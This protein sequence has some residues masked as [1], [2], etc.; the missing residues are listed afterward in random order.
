MPGCRVNCWPAPLPWTV[1]VSVP[2]PP[3]MFNWN[4]PGGVKVCELPS[5]ETVHE[6]AWL[7]GPTTKVS[8]FF[9]PVRLTTSGS[10]DVAVEPSGLMGGSKR[11]VT[12][13]M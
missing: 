4:W 12:G 8:F 3:V 11:P 9:V 13:S 2:P 10:C 1:A 7:P 5:M 6:P